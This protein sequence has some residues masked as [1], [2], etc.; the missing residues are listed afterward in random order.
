MPS[1]DEY[2]DNYLL[3]LLKDGDQSAY[4]A[5]FR[6][7]N[8]LLYLHAYKK[9]QNTEDAKDVIQEVFTTIWLKKTEIAETVNLGGYLYTCVHRRILDRFVHKKSV[10]KYINHFQ[11]FLNDPN[12]TADEMARSRQLSMIIEKEIAALPPKMR[13]IFE[14]SRKQDLSH[15]EIAAQ[16]NISNETVKSQVKN[17]LKILRVKLGPLFIF[18]FF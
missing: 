15:K 11:C 7:Y 10:A 6:R 4:T 2:S 17:A 16:L 5:I 1:Y 12:N 3:H 8:S 14:M 13:Q 18:I 9:L